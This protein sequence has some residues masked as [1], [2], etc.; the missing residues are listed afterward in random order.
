MK[1]IS[2]V[3]FTGLLLTIWF[4]WHTPEDSTRTLTGEVTALEDV[5]ESRG[6]RRITV[7]FDNGSEHII[8]T[9]APF[10]FK[11]GYKAR[12]AVHE[13]YLF[14]DVYR[15]ISDSEPIS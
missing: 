7:R 13:R 8:E 5:P 9:L 2:L 6:L 12:V 10:F 3:G 1:K 11:V 4:L 14:P 15:I